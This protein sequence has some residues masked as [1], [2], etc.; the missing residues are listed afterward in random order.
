MDAL[1]EGAFASGHFLGQ[2]CHG[3]P[4]PSSSFVFVGAVGLSSEARG[5]AGGPSAVALRSVDDAE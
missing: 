1:A 3:L 5:V 2:S 4:Q